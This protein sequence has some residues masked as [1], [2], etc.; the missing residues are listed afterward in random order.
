MEIEKSLI[1]EFGLREKNL[2][3][4]IIENSERLKLI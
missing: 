2:L 1:V 4:N 3:E